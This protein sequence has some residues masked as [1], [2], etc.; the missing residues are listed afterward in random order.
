MNVLGGP[1]S[2]HRRYFLYLR[3]E[4]VGRSGSVEETDDDNLVLDVW[5]GANV[6]HVQLHV[7][8]SAIDGVLG[9][10]VPVALLQIILGPVNPNR[11][12]LPE[13]PLHLQPFTNQDHRLRIIH[14][15]GYD[16]GLEEEIN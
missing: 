1:V 8:P 13:L 10:R 3:D 14:M 4:R 16:R 5:V 2:N 15:T 11:S 9:G 12:C 7:V 6:N